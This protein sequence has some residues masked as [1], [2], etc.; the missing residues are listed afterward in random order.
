MTADTEHSNRSRD[1]LGTLWRDD[2]RRVDFDFLQAP[3]GSEGRI[4]GR[5]VGEGD[6]VW[7]GELERCTLVEAARLVRE[8]VMIDGSVG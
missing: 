2:A 7:Q 4:V 8:S 6:L 5:R 3:V 1:I